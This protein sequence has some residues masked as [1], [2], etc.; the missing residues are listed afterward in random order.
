MWEARDGGAL[1]QAADEGRVGL[2][3]AWLK[4]TVSYQIRVWELSPESQL[5]CA[6]Q[7]GSLGKPRDTGDFL[8]VDAFFFSPCQST[9]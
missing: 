3:S 9:E 1:A 7:K 8:I 4:E 5:N 2:E 6:S